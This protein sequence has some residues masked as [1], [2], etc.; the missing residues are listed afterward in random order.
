MKR[1]WSFSGCSQRIGNL[2][3]IP[4]CSLESYY[5][6][7][8]ELSSPKLCAYKSKLGPRLLVLIDN[9]HVYIVQ[10]LNYMLTQ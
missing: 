6:R 7:T 8:V 2:A 4:S 9:N 1:A 10:V 3:H 5:P